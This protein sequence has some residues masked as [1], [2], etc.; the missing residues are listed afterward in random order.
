[1]G[2]FFGR[3]Y[4]IARVSGALVV[5]WWRNSIEILGCIEGFIG[6]EI[7]FLLEKGDKIVYI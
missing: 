6:E 1:M 4:C 5:A 3:K 2:W 7:V